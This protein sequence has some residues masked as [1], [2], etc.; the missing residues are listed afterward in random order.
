MMGLVLREGSSPV[1]PWISSDGEGRRECSLAPPTEMY[2]SLLLSH[3]I[4]I[5]VLQVVPGEGGKDSR[6]FLGLR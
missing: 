6:L 3:T 4:R 2:G 5:A 1:N